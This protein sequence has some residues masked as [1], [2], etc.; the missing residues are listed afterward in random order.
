MRQTQLR[1]WSFPLVLLAL[2][3]AFG[4]LSGCSGSG[5]N[6]EEPASAAEIG[7]AIEQAVRLDHMNK[8]DLDKI[9]KI[10]RIDKDDIADF[11]LYTSASNVKADELAVIQLKDPGRIA[12]VKEN[13]ELH[14]ERQKAKFK[15]YRPD[16]YYLVERHVMKSK[17]SYV[18][19]A[20]SDQADQMERVFDD[21]F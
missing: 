3:V 16:E 13:I 17:G 21:A 1:I 20:V 4:I 8:G 15:D 12:S 18:L 2:A 5:T 19:F 14:I 7:Q 11:V 10:Y 9:Q 6:A